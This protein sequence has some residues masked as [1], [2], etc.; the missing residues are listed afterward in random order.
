MKIGIKMKVQ[1][2]RLQSWGTALMFT[3]EVKWYIGSSNHYTRGRREDPSVILRLAI[4]MSKYSL[5]AKSFILKKS[6]FRIIHSHTVVEL[7][8]VELLKM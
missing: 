8:E 7:I 4:I 5:L 2:Q 6:S 1:D 3:W